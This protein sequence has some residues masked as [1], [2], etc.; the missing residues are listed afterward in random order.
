MATIIFI[1]KICDFFKNTD[2]LLFLFC[3]AA[4]FISVVLLFSIYYN[5]IV[6]SNRIL[7]V[8]IISILLGIFLSLFISNLNYN[9]IISSWKFHSIISILLVILTFTPLGI[10]REGTDDKAWLNLGII[11]IQPSEL[12]KLSFI[13]TISIHLIYI[14]KDIKKFKNI[15]LLFCH[16]MIPILFVVLQGDYGSALIFFGIFVTMLFIAGIPF[17]YVLLSL[18]SLIIFIPFIW[19][20]LFE[21]HHRQRIRVIFNPML[22]PLNTGFQQLQGRIALGSGMLTGKGLFN[23]N[24]IDNIPEVY[25]DFIFSYIGQTNTGFQ[26]LQGRIALGSGMLTGKGLFNDNIIDNIPEV[27]NDFIFSYIGQTL[28]F[29]GCLIVIFL[30]LF[31]CLRILTIANKSDNNIC[32]YVC[33]GVFS[34]FIFQIIINIGMVLSLMPVIG[35]TLPFFSSGGTSIITMYI[36]IGIVFS[37]KNK[38]KLIF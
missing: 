5:G 12:L 37:M 14:G 34:M 28:G 4:S 11:S 13:I 32:R 33:I 8:Q 36:A 9:I 3:V 6:S 30:L 35:V 31:I 19:F 25:N 17:K 22:D 1:K 15:F 29:I 38:N 18:T 24:I 21:E 23:D 7:I 10:Q 20:F 27:Y 26:Q 16:A 2:K